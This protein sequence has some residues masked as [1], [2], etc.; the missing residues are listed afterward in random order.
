MRVAIVSEYPGRDEVP[1]GGVQVVVRHVAT[2]MAKR[3]GLEVHVVAVQPGIEEPSSEE[4]DGVQV[5]RFPATPRFGNLTHGRAER[6]ATIRLLGRI[7]P[8]IVHAHVLGPPTLAAAESGLPWVAT[9]HG[10]LDAYGKTLAGGFANRVRAWSYTTMERRCLRILRHL[11][12]IS[13]YVR[14]YFGRRI[15]GV[16]TYEIENP[17]AEDF[18]AAKGP[19]DPARIV[20]VGRLVPLKAPETLLDAA[21]TLARQGF[22]FRLRFLGAADDEGYRGQLEARIAELGLAERVEMPGPLPAAR[23]A[24]ELG[25]S[26]VFILPSRQET[27]SVAIMEAMAAGL[28]VV[29]TDVGGTRDLVTE[30]VSGSLVRVGDSGGMADTLAGYLRDP[31]RA[32]REGEAG[33]QIARQRFRAGPIV[34]R[35]LEV[36]REVA[37]G[38]AAEPDKSLDRETVIH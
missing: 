34:D 29:A 15:E 36:Y 11:I 1:R 32:A 26:G 38:G 18:F 30:G 28:P 6:R 23:L 27:A 7:A 16:N 4:M 19:G 37:G 2:E 5:H 35:H 24:E 12:V 3:R 14:R 10:I 25:R 13:P 20:T 9:A 33:R 21:A 8:D 17:V 31:A 22:E